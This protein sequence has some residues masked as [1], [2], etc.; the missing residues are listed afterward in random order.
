[1]IKIPLS[2]LIFCLIIFVYPA[3]AEDYFFPTGNQSFEGEVSD[4]MYDEKIVVVKYD[5]DNDGNYED[6]N[7]YVSG[8]TKIMK[9]DNVV[10]MD[11]LGEGQMVHIDIT[12]DE[13]G[14]H[15]TNDI[16]ILDKQ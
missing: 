14:H 3:L 4:V 5:I 6:V 1:M 7:C 10:T 13:D 12:A 9:G 11:S 8:N 2:L 16:I 15:T